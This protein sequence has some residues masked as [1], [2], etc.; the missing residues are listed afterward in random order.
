MRNLSSRDVALINA[1]QGTFTTAEVTAAIERL[2]LH[3]RSWEL[4]TR[5]KSFH[6]YFARVE[7]GVYIKKVV[8][9]VQLTC[10]CCGKT[11]D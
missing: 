2:D 5:K 3:P 11:M 9:H 6:K 7:H 4:F 1:M 8:G 10:P